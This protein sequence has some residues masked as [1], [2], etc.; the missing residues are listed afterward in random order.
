[1]AL[2][3]AKR[4]NE[5]SDITKCCDQIAGG[6]LF[7][8][9]EPQRTNNYWGRRKRSTKKSYHRRRLKYRFLRSQRNEG[10]KKRPLFGRKKFGRRQGTNAIEEKVCPQ[11]KGKDCK[12]FFCNKVGHFARDCPKRSVNEVWIEEFVNFIDKNSEVYEFAQKREDD[13]DS[14]YSSEELLDEESA[15]SDE[16]TKSESKED[17]ESILEDFEDIEISTFE[18]IDF[19][20][21][22]PRLKNK[23]N[24]EV[25]VASS[26]NAKF[27]KIRTFLN[28]FKDYGSPSL[29]I[30]M[31]FGK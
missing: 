21:I 22:L 4:F 19:S 12:C 10:N 11:G 2:R 7:F 17:L 13:H 5:N 16:W 26:S 30:L 1:M 6:P 25:K 8:G 15:S 29:T 28:N 3:N 18:T 27:I 14:L 9:C 23:P 24:A 31:V 20:L